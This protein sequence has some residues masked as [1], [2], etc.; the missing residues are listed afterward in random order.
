MVCSDSLSICTMTL[1]GAS[2]TTLPG[3]GL[4]PP[5]RI[6]TLSPGVM[7][8][9]T[10]VEWMDLGSVATLTE[11][12]ASCSLRSRSSALV[13]RFGVSLLMER[14]RLFTIQVLGACKSVCS[15]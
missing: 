6:D 9:G 11:R 10:A 3:R 8:G 5:V 13:C 4:E 1:S 12:T 14:P 2:R 7:V 15:M